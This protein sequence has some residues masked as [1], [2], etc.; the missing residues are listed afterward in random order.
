MAI[1]HGFRHPGRERAM[2]VPPA[3]TVGGPN[4]KMLREPKFQHTRVPT[5]PLPGALLSCSGKKV[6]KEAGSGEALT[7]ARSRTRAALP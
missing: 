2:P 5:R 3:H 6:S 4:V 7:R 1:P